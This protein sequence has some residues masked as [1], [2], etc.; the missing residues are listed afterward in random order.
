MTRASGTYL[1]YR[2]VRLTTVPKRL[3]SILAIWFVTQIVLPST[4]PLQTCDLAGLLGKTHQQGTTSR[5]STTTP[6]ASESESDANSFVSPL[7]V[8]ALRASTSLAV[9]CQVATAGPSVSTFGLSPSPQVQHTV[10]R[11]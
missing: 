5:E 1:E 6:L 8:S 9:V 2:R 11:L 4:A 10:L 3:K 7:A